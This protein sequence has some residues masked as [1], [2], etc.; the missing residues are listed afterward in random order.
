MCFSI[1]WEIALCK[2]EKLSSFIK[3]LTHSFNSFIDLFLFIYWLLFF[4]LLFTTESD[5]FK[6]SISLFFFSSILKLLLFSFS[7]YIKFNLSF[8]LFFF[9]FDDSFKFLFFFFWLSIIFFLYEGKF[10]SSSF[11]IFSFL[12]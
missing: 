1:N 9:S 10:I 8:F 12:E 2:K 11:S 3:S 4:C 5:F 6:Y 7:S